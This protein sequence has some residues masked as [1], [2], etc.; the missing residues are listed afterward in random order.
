VEMTGSDC[1]IDFAADCTHCGIC[2][3]N[4]L[5]DVLQKHPLEKL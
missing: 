3:E 4:C 2:A 1:T 5:Y